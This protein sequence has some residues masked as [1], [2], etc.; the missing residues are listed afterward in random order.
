[1]FWGGFRAG[2]LAAFLLLVILAQFGAGSA[3]AA[4][5]ADI[6]I[7]C[8]AS[9]DMSEDVVAIVRSAERWSCSDRKFSI[10]AERVLLRFDIGPDD[11]LP[12]YFLSRRSALM[13]VH[14]F[15]VD[16][17]GTVRQASVPAAA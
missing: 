13:A 17:D 7:S 9:G 10:D 15:A 2:L 16:E 3:S 5:S 11:N 1:M 14:L 8:W 4:D 12:R 6:R